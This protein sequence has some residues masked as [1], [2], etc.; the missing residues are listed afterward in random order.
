M[1]KKFLLKITVIS[2]VILLLFSVIYPNKVYA[3]TSTTGLD[4]VTGIILEPVV[5][6]F[7]FVVDSIM[8][9]FS[10]I[11]TQEDIQ[12]VMKDDPINDSAN[13]GSNIV[14]DNV[15]AYKNI[16]GNL[17]IKYPKFTYSPEE[18]FSDNID[19]LDINF[20]SG[21]NGNQDWKQIRTVISAWYKALRMFAIIGLLSVL[22]YTGIKIIISSTAQDK[23]KYKEKIVNW[24]IAFALL[25]VMH[26]IMAF[27]LIVIEE[28][29]ALFGEINGAISVNINGTQFT[30]NLI[31]LARFQMQ[32]Q[33]FSAKIGY[34]II[35]VAL[36]VFTF[37]FTMLY[38]KRMLSMAFLTLI[39]PIV[40]LMYPIDKM[41]G[42]AQGFQLW[43]KEYIYNALL[44][45]MHYLLYFS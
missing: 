20:I 37:K 6:I 9:V 45:P 18:I 19:L 15:D 22:I 42:K 38:F 16:F 1:R 24:F 30:T 41:E 2:M 34:F 27:I 13:I 36:V 33:H 28:I 35:Y 29:C 3:D 40:A 43:L 11:M 39:A 23:A 32:Q 8:S 31:G 25:F 17:K 14:I 4:T 26:Y 7:T 5:E 21:Q 10:G 44:Q 12:F